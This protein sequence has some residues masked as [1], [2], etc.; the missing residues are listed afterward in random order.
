MIIF[1]SNFIKFI[2]RIFLLQ[3]IR[4]TTLD[5]VIEL[6]NLLFSK[7]NKVIKVG[8]EIPFVREIHMQETYKFRNIFPQSKYP[9]NFI[10][11]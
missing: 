3:S 11:K 8:G 1:S 2:L 9:A 4:H 5:Y 7:K 10:N 6:R